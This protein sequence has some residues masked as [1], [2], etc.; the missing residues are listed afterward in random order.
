MNDETRR[1]LRQ[2]I[3]SLKSL[4]ESVERAIENGLYAGVGEMSARSYRALH[5]K[6]TALLPEDTYVTE[7][8]ALLLPDDASDEAKVASVNMAVSQL[9]PYLEEQIKSAARENAGRTEEFSGE[10]NL[11][12]DDLKELG[13]ELRDRIMRTTRDALRRAM[14]NIDIDFDTGDFPRPPGAPPPPPPHPGK[15]K[16]RI[17]I[18]TGD[19]SL[20]DADLE[21]VNLSGQEMSGKDFRSANLHEAKFNQTNLQGARFQ[22]ANLAGAEM[23]GA[24]LRGANLRSANL[25]EAILNQANLD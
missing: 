12:I 9:K 17:V 19:G 10:F 4:G 18:T 23:V 21:G 20:K 24:N 25:H 22:D 1:S 14:T 15:R 16:R 7:A 2:L 6:V 11:E 8:L 3:P 13:L 5:S